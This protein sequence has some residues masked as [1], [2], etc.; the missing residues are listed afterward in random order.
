MGRNSDNSAASSGRVGE[1]DK[2]KVHHQ[3]SGGVGE[4]LLVFSGA[5]GTVRR[6]AVRLWCTLG[7]Y[8]RCQSLCGGT[9]PKQTNCS[10]TVE[11][12]AQF[13]KHQLMDEAE[14]TGIQ[15]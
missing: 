4:A 3:S 5:S 13:P 7:R 8:S 10:V 12:S 11:R 9:G 2:M 14:Q 15:S 1:V 6:V